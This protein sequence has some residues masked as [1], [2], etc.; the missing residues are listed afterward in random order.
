VDQDIMNIIF[1]HNKTF[2]PLKYNVD[3]RYVNSLSNMRS[4][5]HSAIIHFGGPVKP[6]SHLYKSNQWQK[7]WKKY[8]IEVGKLFQ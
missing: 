8:N 2:L 3:H 6:D 4:L 5:H 1:E 7:M